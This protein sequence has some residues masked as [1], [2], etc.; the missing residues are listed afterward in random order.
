MLITLTFNAFTLTPAKWASFKNQS[1][2]LLERKV[3][4]GCC[5]A[6]DHVNIVA[7]LATLNSFAGNVWIVAVGDIR[8][9]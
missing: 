1:N 9:G 4:L 5:I 2:Q 3:Q 6:D 8:I 7:H